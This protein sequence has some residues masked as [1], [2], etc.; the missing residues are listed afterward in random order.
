MCFKVLRYITSLIAYNVDDQVLRV[1]ACDLGERCKPAQSFKVKSGMSIDYTRKDAAR[2]HIVTSLGMIS[3]AARNASPRR[4]HP[5]N[6]GYIVIDQRGFRTRKGSRNGWQVLNAP[7]DLKGVRAEP[8]ET[9]KSEC[10]Y[11]IGCHAV[12]P[13]LELVTPTLSA[14]STFVDTTVG[15]RCASRR[16]ESP[17]EKSGPEKSEFHLLN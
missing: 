15:S 1:D 12:Y 7:C 10:R 9:G 2:S 3:V 6:P 4:L 17:F 16:E 8:I 11:R 14:Y 13:R 5:W